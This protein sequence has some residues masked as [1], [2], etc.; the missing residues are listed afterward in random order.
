VFWTNAEKPEQKETLSGYG[1]VDWQEESNPAGE[2]AE[3][4]RAEMTK[5]FETLSSPT[6]V[7]GLATSGSIVMV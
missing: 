2:H 4:A 6:C 1:K 3:A 5:G 7:D